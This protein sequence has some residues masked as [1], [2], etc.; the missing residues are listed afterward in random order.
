MTGAG[1]TAFKDLKKVRFIL[2]ALSHLSPGRVLEVGCGS[3]N[4]VR[5]LVD[6][7]WRVVGIDLDI[8]SLR[9]ARQQEPGSWFVAGDA[10]ALPVRSPFDAVICSEVLE[11]LREPN[12][13]SWGCAQF[14]PL[15][16]PS[17]SRCRTGG[18][19]TS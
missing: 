13:R 8:N 3:G 7:G 14:S 15:V 4:I 19:P 10:T 16:A 18:D 6:A 9:Y 2:A 1:Y 11:H 5:T 17:S 12:K